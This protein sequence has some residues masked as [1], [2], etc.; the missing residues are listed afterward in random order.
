MRG[1]DMRLT[2][3]DV[4]NVA[5]S[6][7]P[8]GKRGYNEDEVDQFLDFVETELARLIEEN[9]DLKQRV[10]EPG[11]RPRQRRCVHRPVGWRRGRPRCSRWLPRTRRRGSRSRRPGR[12]P[13]CGQGSR[14]C[15]GHRGSCCRQ[16][17]R[18]GRLVARGRAFAFRR[19]GQRGA[20][21]SRCAPRRRASA[22]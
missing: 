16:C 10:E 18:R 7:P 1:T 9:S 11:G 5:F 4:H 2:P 13:A 17:A 12:K 20:D 6:K 19:H 15:P 22:L 14:A 8:I 21:Q 3:A